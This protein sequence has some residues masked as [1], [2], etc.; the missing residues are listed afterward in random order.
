[1]QVDDAFIAIHAWI[2]PGG[3]GFRRCMALIGPAARLL[4]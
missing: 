2:M 1:M 3:S 4:A